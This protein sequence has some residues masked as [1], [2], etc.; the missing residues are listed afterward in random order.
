MLKHILEMF[1]DILREVL[2]KCLTEIKPPG[3]GEVQAKRKGS[4]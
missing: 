1:N 3:L 2:W 4:F